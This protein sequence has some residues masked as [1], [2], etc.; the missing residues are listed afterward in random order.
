MRDIDPFMR[1]LPQA[2]EADRASRADFAWVMLGVLLVLA[3]A[4]AVMTMRWVSRRGLRR[5]SIGRYSIR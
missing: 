4:V 3:V 5:T 2:F 1:A